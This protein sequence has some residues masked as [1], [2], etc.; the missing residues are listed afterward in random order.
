MKAIILAGGFGMR[1]REV[2]K[3]IPKPMAPVDGRPFLEYLV[4]QLAG[5][6]V[7]EI[8][9]SVGYK[10]DVIR[11]CFGNGERWG[12]RISYSEEKE[13]LGTGGAL[14]KAA[15][16]ADDGR[17]VVMNGDS[18]LNIDM[19]EFMNFHSKKN[20]SATIAL[21]QT[22][23]AGRYGRVETD[24]AGAV[25]N[26]SEKGNGVEGY[27]NGGIYIF[28]RDIIRHV[29][30]G[31]VSLEED[32]LPRFSGNGLYGMPTNGFFIDIGIPEDYLRLCDN[33]GPLA[34]ALRQ[35]E[36]SAI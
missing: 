12:I 3:D 28:E 9:M 21:V 14:K 29:P 32:V 15:G 1:L 11:A 34:A 35:R 22:G 19:D 4:L 20:A 25:V 30:D 33:P 24:G 23:N 17:F 31:K 5:R 6:G 18:F 26:F 8:I 36:W 7:D 27:V 10:G 13:P 16:S 2:I